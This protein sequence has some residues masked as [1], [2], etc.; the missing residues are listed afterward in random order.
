LKTNEAEVR[1]E[2]YMKSKGFPHGRMGFDEKNGYVENFYLLHP[3]LRSLPDYWMTIPKDASRIFLVHVKGTPR[4]KTSDY[5][6]YS[7]FEKVFCKGGCKLVL[8]FCFKDEAPAF[9]PMGA[10]RRVWDLI[11]EQKYENDGKGFKMMNVDSLKSL[12]KK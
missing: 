7:A 2:D 5:A 11:I 12:A 1:F 3:V 9:I 6:R 8:A 4:I 10:V